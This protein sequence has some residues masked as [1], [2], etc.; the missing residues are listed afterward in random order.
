MKLVRTS[1]SLSGKRICPS[2]KE[3]DGLCY[4]LVS[5]KH[6]VLCPLTHSFIYICFVLFWSYQLFRKEQILLD[7]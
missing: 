1:D 3:E 4:L 2:R 7:K 6:L 5:Q